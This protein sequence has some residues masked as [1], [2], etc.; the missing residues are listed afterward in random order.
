MN[1]IV[2]ITGASSGIG[3][4][5]ALLLNEAGYMVYAAS[6]RMNQMNDLKSKGVKILEMDVT[7]DFQMI[8]AIDLIIK[9]EGRIDILINNAGFGLYGALEDVPVEVARYQMEVNVFGLARLTQLVLPHMR[10][11]RSGKIVNITSIA[12]KVVAPYGA[13]YHS[14]KFAVEALSD[15]LR[16]EVKK[17]GIDVIVIEPGV[18]KTE[19]GNTA[20]ENLLKYSG[21]SEYQ[22]GALATATAFNQMFEKG[23]ETSVI[24]KLI[25][26]AI[27]AKHPKTRYHGGYMASL[28]LFARK[29]FS[30][31][32]FDK[33]IQMQLGK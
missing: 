4:K 2:L 11:Q 16:N 24:A 5:T 29:L 6:R 14:S 18:I 7:Q 13:W 28:S 21:N 20:T 22:Q 23:F 9:E 33:L 8:K 1:K 32:L 27:Q 31:K 19:F 3:K 17:F 15:A 30:D 12:G 26:K 10:Q 25:G